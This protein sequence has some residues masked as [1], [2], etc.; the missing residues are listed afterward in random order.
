[1]KKSLDAKKKLEEKLSEIGNDKI[2][3]MAVIVRKGKFLIGLR[4]YTA[5]KWKNISVWTAPGGR[6]EEDEII[7]KTLRREVEEETGISDLTITEFIGQIKG[8]KEGD[9]VYLFLAETNQEAVN[10]EPEKFSGWKWTSVSDFP[11]NYINP[12]ALEMIKKVV[13]DKVY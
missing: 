11:K 12:E 8:A 7:E 1:M 2:C 13:P 6:C 3:P 4:N 5:D 9:I 10:I